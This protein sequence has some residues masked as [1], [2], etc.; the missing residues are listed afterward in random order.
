MDD[1]DPSI[2]SNFRCKDSF[3]VFRIIP[4]F[5]PIHFPL[6]MGKNCTKSIH[7]KCSNVDFVQVQLP[8]LFDGHMEGGRKLRHAR[9][10]ELEFNEDLGCPTF[11]QSES[12]EHRK[13]HTV[14][15][16][17][18]APPGIYKTL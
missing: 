8:W 16:R 13:H 5:L 17:N 6:S 9:H 15:G 3:L 10:A 2:R 7:S 4:P 18:P 11:L 1:F 12:F 14:D